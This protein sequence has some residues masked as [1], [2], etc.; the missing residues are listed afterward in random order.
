MASSRWWFVG[1]VAVAAVSAGVGLAQVTSPS[2]AD[3]VRDNTETSG[4]AAD[5]TPVEE[6]T[7]VASTT[8]NRIRALMQKGLDELKAARD[9]KDIVRVTC[10]NEAVAT[11]KGVLRVGEDANATMLEALSLQNTA[12]ARREF[13]K[14]RKAQTRMEALLREVQSCAGAISSESTS[15]IDLSIDENLIG[16]DPYYGNPNFFFDPQSAV[17]EGDTNKLGETDDVTVRPPPASGVS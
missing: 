1:A 14:V 4:D 7:E 3:V 16:S 5:Q 13:R 10:V 8:I 15:S 2:D 6:Y 17:A 9:E 11:M 12:D